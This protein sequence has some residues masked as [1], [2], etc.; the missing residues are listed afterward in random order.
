MYPS[1]GDSSVKI[2]GGIEVR[3]ETSCFYCTLIINLSRRE[4]RI[5]ALFVAL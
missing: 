3:V 1:V 2:N 4:R 5:S